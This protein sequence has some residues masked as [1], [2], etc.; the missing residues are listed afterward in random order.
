[1]TYFGNNTV[2]TYLL[3]SLE[4]NLLIDSS[5]FIKKTSIFDDDVIMFFVEI[6]FIVIHQ[7]LLNMTGTRVE[8]IDA[9]KIYSL[10]AVFAL[11]LCK[12]KNLRCHQLLTT[13]Y[14]Q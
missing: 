2:I 10:A 1:M 8:S 14:S 4:L 11:I 3:E 9:T 5:L 6:A 13:N 7:M 12:S